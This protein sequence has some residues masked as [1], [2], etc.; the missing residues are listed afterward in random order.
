MRKIVLS[1][2]RLRTE[3]M[4][5]QDRGDT[6]TSVAAL[7]SD[8]GRDGTVISRQHDD[9]WSVTLGPMRPPEHHE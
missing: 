5:E 4:K 7:L 1:L 6:I 9:E 2:L 8:S 3:R